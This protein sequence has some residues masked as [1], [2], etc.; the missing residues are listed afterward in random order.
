MAYDL[1][2]NLLQDSSDEFPDNVT[3]APRDVNPIKIGAKDNVHGIGYSGLDPRKALHGKH[4][5]LFPAP[6]ITK[7][8]KR[9]IRGTVCNSYYRSSV[10]K[11]HVGISVFEKNDR[12][13]YPNTEECAKFVKRAGVRFT[14]NIQLRQ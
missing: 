11:F 14:N 7:T 8:G 13:P 6:A 4:V 10:I 2:N 9:G 3:F 5:N 1:L 12:N